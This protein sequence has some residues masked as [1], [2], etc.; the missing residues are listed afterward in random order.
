MGLG[1][2]A[3]VVAGQEVVVLVEQ[4]CGPGGGVDVGVGEPGRVEG[5]ACAAGPVSLRQ[6]TQD[7]LDATNAGVDGA[8]AFE[9]VPA[10]QLHGAHRRG[11]LRP[12]P[13]GG[14]R[15]AETGR[16]TEGA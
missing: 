11:E 8:F 15:D 13:A 9:A 10:G 12:G 14:G 4:G 7:I 16:V 1:L 3:T 6:G 5:T 2:P